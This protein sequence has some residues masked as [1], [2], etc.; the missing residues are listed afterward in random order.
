MAIS[1]DT[2]NSGDTINKLCKRLAY[3]FFRL[4]MTNVA[5]IA[6]SFNNQAILKTLR[7]KESFAEKT[8]AKPLPVSMDASANLA[9]E[10]W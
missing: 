8:Q 9:F 10:N 4:N 5:A 3:C 7:T 6:S 2:N 1:A